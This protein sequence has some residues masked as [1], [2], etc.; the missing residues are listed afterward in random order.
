MGSMNPNFKY[1]K[2]FSMFDE[3]TDDGAYILGLIWSDGTVRQNTVEIALQKQDRQVLV[4]ISKI[5]FGK[6]LVTDSLL[7]PMSFLTINDKEFVNR[8]L[9]YGGICKG[10][11]SDVLEFPKIPD[12]LMTSFIAGYF[13]GDGAIYDRDG[14]PRFKISSNSKKII[15]QII[16]H[17]NLHNDIT[18]D[19]KQFCLEVS[20]FRA[21]DLCQEIYHNKKTL[22]IQ[23]KYLAYFNMLNWQ[24]KSLWKIQPEFLVKKIDRRAQVPIKKRSTDSGYDVAAIILEKVSGNNKLWKADLGIAVR[25]PTGWYFDLIGRSSLPMKGWHFAGGTGVIDQSYTGSIM[26]YLEKIDDKPLPELPFVCAQLV[27]RPFIHAIPILVD[28]LDETSRGSKGFGSS[29]AKN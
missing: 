25:P 29:D 7:R 21:L 16:D 27:L 20:G 8:I 4:D 9:S 28:E 10:K 18:V 5:I 22:K 14:Y 26:M 19:R 1:A 6:D 17:F 12:H 3:L 11:K 15:L 2:D 13:D 24:P 23:R